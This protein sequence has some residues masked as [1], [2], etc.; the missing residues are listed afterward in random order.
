MPHAFMDHWN[1]RFSGGLP[2]LDMFSSFENIASQ[3]SKIAFSDPL[4]RSIESALL[5]SRKRMCRMTMSS[6]DTQNVP[7]FSPKPSPGAVCP[8]MVIFEEVTRSSLL[9]CA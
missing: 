4:S 2:K 3:W 6:P 9:M 7:S 8:A 1:V 5:P